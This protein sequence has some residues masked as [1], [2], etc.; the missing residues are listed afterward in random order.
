MGRELGS[1]V[2]EDPLD[3]FLLGS[4]FQLHDRLENV[5]A[6]EGEGRRGLMRS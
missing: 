4:E 6:D 1:V 3:D 2:V 5:D